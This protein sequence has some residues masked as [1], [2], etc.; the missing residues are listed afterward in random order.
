[1]PLIKLFGIPVR[2]HPL[3]VIVMLTSLL[4]GF[5]VELV[6]LFSIVVIHEL[7]HVIAAR[8]FRWRIAEVQLLP[9]GGVMVAEEQGT[10]PAS[11]D[12]IVAL[13]GP[14]Q[15]GLL[16]IAALIFHRIGWWQ[17][18]WSD[19]FI[20][21]NVMIGCF[22]LLP[23]MPLDGGKLMQSLVS[24]S[25]NYYRSI[26]YCT[27][28]GLI[29]SALLALTSFITIETV[30]IQLN[31]LMISLFLFYANIYHLRHVPYHYIRF[32][33]NRPLRAR[34][35]IAHGVRACP[36]VVSKSHPIRDIIHMFMRE[37]Y[38]LI[39]VIN[40]RG[41]IQA[42]VPEQRLITSFLQEKERTRA[43]SDIFMLK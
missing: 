5:F 16:I 18:D 41:A 38:H 4:T 28:F 43:V 27:W 22:N 24:F 23:I 32:L 21:A 30:G 39:Y 20:R 7:G 40:E 10:T 17:S 42:V 33:V 11:E 9:F 19:Y 2:F 35:W 3:F 14:L 12:M 13:A 6:T 29:A 31:L 34:E 15:N 8:A 36:I 1:M 25:M 37:K 26:I